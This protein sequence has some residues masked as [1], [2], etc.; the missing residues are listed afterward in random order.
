M[1]FMLK[2]LFKNFLSSLFVFFDDIPEN[3]TL[4]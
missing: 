2:K 3:I 1:H 4:S